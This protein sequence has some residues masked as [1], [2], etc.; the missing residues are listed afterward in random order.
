MEKEKWEMSALDAYINKVYKFV[1]IYV[2]M[3]CILAGITVTA[4]YLA[5]CYTVSSK[6]LLCVFDASVIIY[7]GIGIYLA[8]TGYGENGIVRPDKLKSAKIIT[9]IILFLQWNAIAYIWPFRDMWAFCILFT[10]VVALFFDIRLVL[11]VT[12]A[13]SLSMFVSWAVKG[14]WLLPDPGTYFNANMVFRLVGLALMLLSI[15]LITCFGGKFF[16]EELEKYVNY[17]TLTHL[18]NR[19]SLDNYLNAAY[20]QA[21]KGKTTFCL[22]LM[23]IDDFKRVNDTYGHE[24]GDEV[25]QSVAGIIQCGVRKNDSVFRWG[26]EE[27]LVL[28]NAEEYKAVF[29]A[30]RIR[31]EIE[32]TAVYYK[33]NEIFVTVT[34]GVAPYRD[35]SGIQDMMDQ[36]DKCLYYGKKH[37]K[38]QVVSM[39]ESEV[40]PFNTMIQ[41]LSGLPNASGYMRDVEMLKKSR[42]VSEYSAFYFNIKRFGNINREIGQENG[43]DLLRAYADR[44]R[45][46]INEDELVGHLGGDN[47]MAMIRKERQEEMTEFLSGVRVDLELKEGIRTFTLAATI[48][49]WRIDDDNIEPGEI[50]SRP[51]LAL[52][53]ARNVRHKSVEIISDDQITRIRQQKNV[54]VEYKAALQNEEFHVFYQ[55]KVDSRTNRLVGA[56]GLVRWVRSGETVSPGIFIPPLEESGEI[57]KL[58]YYVLRHVCRDMVRWEKEGIEPVKVSVN[59]SRKDLADK[60][61]ADNINTIIEESGI[62]RKLIEIEVTETTDE[63]EQGA[64]SEFISR[65]YSFGITTAIDDFG[66]GYSSIVSLR[67]FRVKTLKIDRSFINTDD[68]SWKDEVILKDIIHMAQELGM[69]IITEGVERQDQLLFVNS[70]GCFI[71]QGFF[72]DRPLPVEEFEQRLRQK[73]YT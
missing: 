31:K 49:I 27:I 17:D 58:D 40:T 61:L 51:S 45:A 42:S 67:D 69:D 43:D 14:A 13:I 34:I 32:K 36:A 65:L 22:L 73:D 8:H 9:G 28:L 2:P 18:M 29:I 47:F 26:G 33:G 55:P 20:R 52:N 1:V 25:L 7:L 38:N 10:I 41:L 11:S 3:L 62:D 23:D 19:R 44:V 30:D 57:L 15:N 16:V 4:L 12:A 66:A 35:G 68:F 21:A 5:G 59:F 54:L 71:I 46:F 6:A 56:E 64:L 39:V 70:A 37:G 48:G 53:Q 24:C 60:Q 50:I 63:E 72:Y